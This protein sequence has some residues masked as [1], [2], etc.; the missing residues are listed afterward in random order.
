MDRHG[1]AERTMAEVY[2][3]GEPEDEQW[4]D[5]EDWD[6]EETEEEWPHY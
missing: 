3:Y 1:G 2:L 6:D 4:D 5:S